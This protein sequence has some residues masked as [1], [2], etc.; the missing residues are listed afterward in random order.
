MQYASR[1]DRASFAQAYLDSIQA[2][3]TSPA[4]SSIDG[5]VVGAILAHKTLGL[6]GPKVTML[7]AEDPDFFIGQLQASENGLGI[8]LPESEASLNEVNRGK[9]EEVAKGAANV[10]AATK[11]MFVHETKALVDR[12]AQAMILGSKTWD[13]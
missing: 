5:V 9:M 6:V 8:L 10:K 13:S 7:G 3:S 11:A 4:K 12:G 2:P 1:G